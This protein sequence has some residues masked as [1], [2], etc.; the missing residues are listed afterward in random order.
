MQAFIKAHCR[1]GFEGL[2]TNRQKP[3]FNFLKFCIKIKSFT[4]TDCFAQCFYR[5]PCDFVIGKHLGN[6][7]FSE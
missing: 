3:T 2:R 4:N 1:K 7:F 6:Q 5:T